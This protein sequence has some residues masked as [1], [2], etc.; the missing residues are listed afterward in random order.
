MSTLTEGCSGA[1]RGLWS[2]GSHCR[3]VQGRQTAPAPA[4]RARLSQPSGV[5]PAASR[6]DKG[7]PLDKAPLTPPQQS[8]PACAPVGLLV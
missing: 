3:L 6:T 7:A 1:S 4:T 5:Q 8:P 2:P